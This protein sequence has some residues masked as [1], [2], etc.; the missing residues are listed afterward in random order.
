VEDLI[1]FVQGLV[2]EGSRPFINGLLAAVA[3]ILAL[4]KLVQP[5]LA[6]RH[7]R[8]RSAIAAERLEEA[9]KTTTFWDGWLKAHREVNSAED[10]ALAQTRVRAELDRILETLAVPS[11]HEEREERRSQRSLVRKIFLLYRPIGWLG[12]LLHLGFYFFMIVSFFYIIGMSVEP[13]TDA[14]SWQHFRAHLGEMLGESL[15]FIVPLLLLHWGARGLRRR[16]E[17]A[18]V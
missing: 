14:F 2:P 5:M 18:V 17:N 3:V 7:G 13:T 11:A 12:W 4:V 8:R 9:I 1:K 6:M 10:V 16:Q 15:F